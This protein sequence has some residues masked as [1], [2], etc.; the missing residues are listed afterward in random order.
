[1]PGSYKNS[2]VEYKDDE[3]SYFLELLNRRPKAFC[4][5]GVP[6]VLVYSVSIGQVNLV[7]VEYW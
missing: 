6:C 5:K 2:G 4:T 3:N 7:V 1:M